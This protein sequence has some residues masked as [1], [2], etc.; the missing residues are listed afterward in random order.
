MTAV[1]SRWTGGG[2]EGVHFFCPACHEVHTIKHS[3]SGW[4]FNGDLE[5]P[6][7]NP[8][9]LARGNRLTRDAAGKWT[10]EWERDTAGNL[11]P[12]VCHSFVRGGRIEFLSDCTHAL[13]GQTVDLPPWPNS[14]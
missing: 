8:S 4:T 13:A 2:E 5:R 11:I 9:V 12:T 7:F 10:G 3:P 1:A 6:T 14:D